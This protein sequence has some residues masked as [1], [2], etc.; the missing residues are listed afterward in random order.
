MDAYTSPLITLRSQFLAALDSGEEERVQYARQAFDRALVRSATAQPQTAETMLMYLTSTIASVQV[1]AA[2]GVRWESFNTSPSEFL[3]DP[4]V[5]E[6]LGLLFEV[7]SII[8]QADGFDT[9]RAWLLGSN[10]R[11]GDDTPLT[12]IRELRRGEVVSAA[13]SLVSPGGGAGA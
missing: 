13:L 3:D 6:R 8:A 5:A 4:V 2:L 9:L 11:L 1:C 7:W 10:L 12:A